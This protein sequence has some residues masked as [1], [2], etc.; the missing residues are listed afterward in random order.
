VK[1][2][3]ALSFTEPEQLTALAETAEAVGFDGVLVS[4]HLFFPAKL[5]SRYPY[6]SDGT[7]GF[8]PDTPW[9]EPW[10]AIA[11]MAAVTPRLRVV[12]AGQ[13]L[14]PLHPLRLAQDLNLFRK[15]V[16]LTRTEDHRELGEWW[17]RLDPVCRWGGRFSRPDGNHYSHAWEGRA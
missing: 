17:E 4:D 13:S 12:S 14:P 10:S 9:P 11:A 6:S 16:W 15:G 5:G 8:G 7:P 1:F 3:Q 2:W